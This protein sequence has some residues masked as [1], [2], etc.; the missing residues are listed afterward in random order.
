MSSCVLDID[1]KLSVVFISLE[2][3]GGWSRRLIPLN[4]VLE[5]TAYMIHNSVGFDFIP[6]QVAKNRN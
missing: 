4:A 6:G 3:L 2:F 5:E 1:R